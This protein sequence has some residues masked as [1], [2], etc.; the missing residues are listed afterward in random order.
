MKFLKRIK[1][2][3]WDDKNTKSNRFPSLINFR[4][5]WKVSVL[6]LT[7][8]SIV[9]L[10]FISLID[11]NKSKN[12]M[13]SAVLLRTSRFTSNTWRTISF[14]LAERLL[15]LDFIVQDNS[16]EQLC[17]PEKLLSIKDNLREEVG[18]FT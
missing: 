11:Y 18:G 10:L 5:V 16:Y 7:A 8:V 3:F 6:A 17:D 4:R 12:A 15:A 9:P 1:P 13:E 2:D 14:F